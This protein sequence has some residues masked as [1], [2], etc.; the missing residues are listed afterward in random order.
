MTDVE[1]RWRRCRSRR[2]NSRLA[3]CR[4]V[5]CGARLARRGATPAGSSAP[6]PAAARAAMSAPSSSSPPPPLPPRLARLARLARLLLR[7]SVLSRALLRRSLLRRPPLPPPPAAWALM[8]SIAAAAAAASTKVTK[9]CPVQSL[10]WRSISSLSA[11]CAA[12]SASRSRTRSEH[13]ACFCWLRVS[14]RW[15]CLVVTS[16]RRFSAGSIGGCCSRRRRRLQRA[17]CRSCSRRL[18]SG[19]RSSTSRIAK[20]M[21]HE[22]TAPNPPIATA[23]SLSAGGTGGSPSSI[24]V[25]SASVVV[26]GAA[27]AW[28]Y[29]W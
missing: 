4:S 11:S 16:G 18:R 28:W 7:R 26:C 2:E 24:T 1:T 29:G 21:W 27:A 6:T 25:W 5:G 8:A 23:S 17:A 13:A 12:S 19:M 9:A 22:C 3:H 15:N 10:G 14:L 20:A